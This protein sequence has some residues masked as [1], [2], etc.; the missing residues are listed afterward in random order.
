[1]ETLEVPIPKLTPEWQDLVFA[2]F[3]YLK[4]HTPYPEFIAAQLGSR[5]F[6]FTKDGGI[7]FDCP[8]KAHSNPT[9]EMKVF[10]NKGTGYCFKCGKPGT[11]IVKVCC[12]ITGEPPS[13]IYN[14]MCIPLALPLLYPRPGFFTI[15]LPD[16]VAQFKK[17][18]V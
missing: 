1:M 8:L 15:F 16:F 18:G 3:A 12:A 6:E 13:I 4:K 2:H 14:R 5:R 11:D 7:K 9:M 10:K 17:A